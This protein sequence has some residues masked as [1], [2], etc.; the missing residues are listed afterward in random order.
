MVRVCW[1]AV[2]AVLLLVVVGGKMYFRDNE[3]EW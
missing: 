1:Q 2:C 3:E